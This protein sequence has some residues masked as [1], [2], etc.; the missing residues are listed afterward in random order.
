MEIAFK[1]MEF[2]KIDIFV[3]Y[4]VIYDLIKHIYGDLRSQRKYF[5]R[6]TNILQRGG[7]GA[8]EWGWCQTCKKRKNKHT[9]TLYLDTRKSA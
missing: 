7:V 8:E 6:K 1:P 5:N 3:P 9:Y 2:P 4:N